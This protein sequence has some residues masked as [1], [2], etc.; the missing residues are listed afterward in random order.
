MMRGMR[1]WLLLLLGSC[2]PP[3]SCDCGGEVDTYLTTGKST[4]KA[5]ATRS[6]A[7]GSTTTPGGGAAGRSAIAPSDEEL[8]KWAAP[9]DDVAQRLVDAKERLRIVP[10]AGAQVAAKKPLGKGDLG[11][12]LERSIGDFSAREDLNEGTVRFGE[13]VLPVASRE[14]GDGDRTLYLKLTDTAAAPAV[15]QQVIEELTQSGKR[16]GTFVRGDIVRGYP[17]IFSYSPTHA[18]SKAALLV[19]ERYLIELRIHPTPD[20]E[21]AR[22]VFEA[23]DWSDLAKPKGPDG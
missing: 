11:D 19:G 22:R 7:S 23:L 16:A 15:H 12:V 6:S 2:A 1:P 14:Y 13:A 9:Q 8:G 20:P 17:G 3:C 21:E 4:S 18:S 5:S 10:D